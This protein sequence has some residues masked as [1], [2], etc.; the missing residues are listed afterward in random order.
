MLYSGEWRWFPNRFAMDMALFVDAGMVAPRF[1]DLKFTRMKYDYGVGV[2]LHGPAVT[3]LRIDA[4]HSDEG[5]HL[6][7]AMSAPF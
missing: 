6:V 4:A 2:R 5:F 7:F 1:R 3:T